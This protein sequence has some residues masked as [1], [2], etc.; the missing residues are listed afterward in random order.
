MKTKTIYKVQSERYLESDVDIMIEDLEYYKNEKDAEKFFE[1]IV[2]DLDI[3]Y[4]AYIYECKCDVTEYNED[5]HELLNFCVV[6]ILSCEIIRESNRNNGDYIV[7]SIVIEWSYEKHVGYARNLT[8]IFI[9][10]NHS[11]MQYE[12]D[13]ITGNEDSVGRSNYSVLLDAQEVKEASNLIEVIYEQLSKEYWRWNHFK[14]N[15]GSKFIQEKI[16]NIAE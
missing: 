8:D 11:T 5:E 13:L 2:D 10:D 12:V 15:P 16:N 1:A 3:G 6:N 4:T 14:N 9:I 7:G